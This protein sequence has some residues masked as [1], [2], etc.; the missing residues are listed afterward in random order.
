LE[1]GSM[2]LSNA[3]VASDILKIAVVNRY[4]NLAPA[5]AYINGFGL[6]KGAIASSVAHDSHNVIAVGV[7]DN[8]IC[9]AVNAVIRN[10]GGLAVYDGSAV[11]SLPLPVAGLM[12]LDNAKTVGEKYQALDQRAKALGCT[13]RAP[14]MTASFMALL[15]IPKLK[16]SDKGLFDAVSFQFTSVDTVA[17]LG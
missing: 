11:E 16:L 10:K 9:E 12:S 14:F 15:V 1:S 6:K 2:D 7:D 3:L 13:L 8:A 4:A 17:A 5:V